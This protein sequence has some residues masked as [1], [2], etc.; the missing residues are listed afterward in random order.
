[1]GS[2][3]RG[4]GT[5]G[6]RRQG[7]WGLPPSALPAT[8]RLSWLLEAPGLSPKF[9]S[10]WIKLRMGAGE[11]R[12]EAGLAGASQLSARDRGCTF[13][14]PHWLSV[15]QGQTVSEP[16]ASA[17]QGT[18][19]VPPDT[20]MRMVRAAPA[21]QCA[22]QVPGAARGSSLWSRAAAGTSGCRKCFTGWPALIR[23]LC[24]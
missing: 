8:R 24:S 1:M 15:K 18:G 12:Q 23:Q 11:A 16:P 13:T 19:L 7:C 14:R 6:V 9:A 21:G 2:S 22:L 3:W 10:V 17:Y 4:R 20:Q 5:G